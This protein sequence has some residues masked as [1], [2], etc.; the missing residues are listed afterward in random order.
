MVETVTIITIETITGSI[1]YAIGLFL[2]GYN[3]SSRL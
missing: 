2:L 3:Y 1:G